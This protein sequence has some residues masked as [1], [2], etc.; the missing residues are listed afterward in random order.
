M[1]PA[2]PDHAFALDEA[3]FIYEDE[4][5]R[6]GIVEDKAGYAMAADGVILALIAILRADHPRLLG[7]AAFATLLSLAFA[8]AAYWP[9]DYEFPQDFPRT[10][11]ERADWIRDNSA[12]ATS[13]HV[14]AALESASAN[15]VKTNRRGTF[16][17]IA[18]ITL[19][20]ALAILL[21]VFGLFTL[22][23]FR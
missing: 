21:L 14:E 16:V 13:Q 22:D 3:R 4:E 15:A 18:T 8:I 10:A 5:S 6:R 19:S 17:L 12:G 7:I 11:A 1:I 9:V 2:T 23:A 20:V